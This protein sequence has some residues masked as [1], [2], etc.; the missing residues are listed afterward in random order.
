MKSPTTVLKVIQTNLKSNLS[1]FFT[2]DQLCVEAFENLIPTS[3]SLLSL[4]PPRPSPLAL[5]SLLPS[6]V[7][8]SAAFSKYRIIPPS[9]TTLGEA[10]S[11]GNYTSPVGNRKAQHE[12][13]SG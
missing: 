9:L 4:S 8:P 5:P 6:V 10:R 11:L 2:V 3:S 13:F 7:R 12:W 1:Y